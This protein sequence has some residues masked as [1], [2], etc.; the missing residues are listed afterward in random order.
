MAGCAGIRLHQAAG[1]DAAWAA[2]RQH[3]PAA[4]GPPPYWAIA[5]PGARALARYLTD[6]PEVVRG[7]R[8]LELGCGGALAALAAARAGASRVLA[9]DIDPLAGR[10]AAANA[11]ANDLPFE[12]R[13]CDALAQPAEPVWDVVLAADLW[14]ERFLAPR[15]TAWLQGCAA[16]GA[17]VLIG[18]VGRAFS[19]RRGLELL[20]CVELTDSHGTER[21][22]RLLARVSAL[23]PGVRV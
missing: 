17:R 20:Q 16:R 7:R 2:L 23:G 6:R 22:E 18:D 1:L 13:V 21:G 10:V 19:P 11:A 9:L 14:Y 5:W 8:V 15:A 12:T 4:A 3:W